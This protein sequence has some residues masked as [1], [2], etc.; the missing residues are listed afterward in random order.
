M[1]AGL[2]KFALFGLVVVTVVLVAFSQ[3][4]PTTTN[5]GYQPE[6]PIPFSHKLHAGQYKIDCRYCH[7]T[8]YRSVHAGVPPLATCMNCHSV[9]KTESPWIQKIQKSY[10]EGK[11]IEWL[12]VHELPD[13]AHFNHKRHLAKGVQCETC[14]GN[15]KEMDRVYQ[16]QPLNMGWC[17]NCHRGF[18]TPKYVRKNVFPDHPDGTD[19]VAPFSCNTCHY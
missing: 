1:N 11:P 19:P 13:H 14:H 18:E 4:M 16:D 6:Q 10:A 9:V 12:R 2:R 5:E 3:V 17:L 15:V 8:A 7:T